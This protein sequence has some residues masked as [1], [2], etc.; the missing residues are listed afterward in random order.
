MTER[1]T[2]PADSPRQADGDFLSAA[3]AL[4]VAIATNNMV[5]DDELDALAMAMSDP[6]LAKALIVNLK[7]HGL[8]SADAVAFTI[9]YRRP[10]L[11]SA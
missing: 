10:M 3:R 5:G 9:G 7:C 8:A 2:A 4:L 6:T 11:R 1:E